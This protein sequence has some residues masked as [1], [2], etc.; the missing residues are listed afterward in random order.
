M[1]NKMT[2][3][4]HLEFLEFNIQKNV[5]HRILYVKGCKMYIHFSEHIERL[6]YIFKKSTGHSHCTYYC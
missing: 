3:E 1:N 4:E 5:E 6:K 2:L